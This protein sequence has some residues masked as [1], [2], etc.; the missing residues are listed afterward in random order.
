MHIG[1]AGL[2]RMGAAMALRLLDV[3]HAVTVWNRSSDKLKAAIE[4]GAKASATPSELASAAD[5][6]LT[7]LTDAAAIASVYEG[8][9]GLLA[10]TIAGKTMVEMSTVRPHVVTALGEKVRAKGAALID[11]PVGGTVGPARQ[12]K[13]LG[14]A[15]GAKEDVE[16]LRPLLEQLC[17]RVDHV[18]PLGSG[19]SMKL[20]IN[21]PLAISFQALGEAY[22]L[23]RDL[24]L[25]PAYVMEI[26]SESSG[27]TTML[28]T[29][30]PAIAQVLAGK[31]GQPPAVA[32]EVLRKDVAT[33]VE[34]ARGRGA[35]LPLASVALAILE[36]AEKA[37]W[38]GKD[39]T[40]LPSFWPASQKSSQ[41]PEKGKVG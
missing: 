17:R 1:I 33:M 32:I 16:R 35:E 14:L 28:K 10:G 37:G 41:T 36:Q 22:I 34:E 23:C 4:S 7:I 12:G 18:G 9:Q 15:G 30:A 27:A 11:C 6:T 21:L 3:G 13:L 20:A 5:V 38:G 29:R 2:G 25:D 39:A 8:P 19:T 24:G 26:F 40:E 31:P